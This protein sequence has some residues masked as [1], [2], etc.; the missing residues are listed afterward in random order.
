MQQPKP[1]LFTK[2]GF[3]TIKKEQEDLLASRPAAVEDLK[4]ARE[5]GDLSENGYYKGARAK[6][7]SIDH[8][9]RVLAHMIRFA[10][11][12]EVGA[13]GVVEIGA[14]VHLKS[15]NG[16]IAYMIVGEQE[17]NPSEKKISHVSPL[18]KALLGKKKGDVIH[19]ETPRGTTIFT[20]TSLD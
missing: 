1:I 17:A 14:T 8:R 5:M 12:Q 9:L 3:D 11:V 4:K 18:G 6:L 16:E 15:D 2:A 10:K 20:I 19:F 13:T 7:S